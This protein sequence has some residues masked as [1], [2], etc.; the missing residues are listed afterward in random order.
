MNK[1]RYDMIESM[2]IPRPHYR[3]LSQSLDYQGKECDWE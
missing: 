2:K 3:L 1:M